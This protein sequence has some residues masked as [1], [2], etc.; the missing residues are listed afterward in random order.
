MLF[1]TVLSMGLAG[2]LALTGQA[3]GLWMVLTALVS[4]TLG[5]LSIPGLFAR[6]RSGWTLLLYG[7]LF[8][9]LVGL[10]QLSLIGVAAGA[11]VTWL[12]FQVKRLY[13]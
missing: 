6:K 7:A 9:A 11:L 12:A 8:H 1:S 13:A 10:L 5:V 3:Q 2:L 4:M